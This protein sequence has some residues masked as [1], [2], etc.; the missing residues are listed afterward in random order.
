MA[1]YQPHDK[2]YR[3]A[4]AQ[5]LVSR[6]AFK[7]EEIITRSRL[8]RRDA[9]IVDLGCAPGGWLVIEVSGT[10]AERVRA[11]MKGWEEIKVIP[12]LQSI[13]RVIRARRPRI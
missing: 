8:V 5:G 2:Y 9:R 6:A 13:P 4:R 12:D 3:K 7:I 10:I 11:L 1:T